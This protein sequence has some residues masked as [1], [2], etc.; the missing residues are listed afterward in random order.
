MKKDITDLVLSWVTCCRA[1]WSNWFQ[2]RHQAVCRFSEVENALFKALV[3]DELHIPTISPTNLELI[4]VVYQQQIKE[5]RQFCQK[6]KAGNIFCRSVDI[7]FVA[8]ATFKL[9]SIDPLGTMMDGEPYAEVFYQDGFILEPTG[10]LLYFLT[11]H[12]VPATTDSSPA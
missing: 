7:S 9:R 1:T 6:Q 4:D 11:V 8:N 5:P 10:K 12:D 2:D 3:A